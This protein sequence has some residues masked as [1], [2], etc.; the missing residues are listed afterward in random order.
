ME[1]FLV[2]SYM[3]LIYFDQVTQLRLPAV[4]FLY[5]NSPLSFLSFFFFLTTTFIMWKKICNIFAFLGLAHFA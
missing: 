1:F 3:C 4:P 2:F 5:S